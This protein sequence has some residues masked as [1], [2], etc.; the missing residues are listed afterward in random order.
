MFIKVYGDLDNLLNP[1]SIVFNIGPQRL[2]A[3]LDYFYGLPTG[4]AW[5]RETYKNKNNQQS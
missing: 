1:T 4:H 2:Q 3:A 5:L